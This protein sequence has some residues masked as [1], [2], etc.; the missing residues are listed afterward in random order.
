ME[1]WNNDNIK[2]FYGVGQ[3]ITSTEPTRDDQTSCWMLEGLFETE[4]EAIDHCIYDEYFVVPVPLGIMM[5]MDLPD[6]AWYPRLQTKEEGQVAIDR[7]RQ[8]LPPYPEEVKDDNEE[9]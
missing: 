9:E 5:G 2:K 1:W 8:G 4:Q 6:G 3:S 7:I